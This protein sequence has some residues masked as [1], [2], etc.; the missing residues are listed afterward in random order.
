MTA[1]VDPHE[2]KARELMTPPVFRLLEFEDSESL[3][4]YVA[5]ALR[6]A[7]EQAR[8]DEREACAYECENFAV[9]A[10]MSAEVQATIDTARY[11][12]KKIRARS[13]S[14]KEGDK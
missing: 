3:I 8:A 10:V 9:I 5:E 2:T 13:G 11:I 6:A 7:A 1:P 4:Y 14:G 12:A